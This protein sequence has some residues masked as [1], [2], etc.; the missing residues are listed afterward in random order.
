[1]PYL[2]T[3]DVAL[4]YQRDRLHPTADGARIF[5]ETLARWIAT[6]T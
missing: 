1:V 6:Q 5:G 2:S 4:P 3:L